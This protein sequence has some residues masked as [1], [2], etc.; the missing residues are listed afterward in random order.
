M[1]LKPAN[2]YKII[3]QNHNFKK[4]L[5]TVSSIIYFFTEQKFWNHHFFMKIKKLK[6][7]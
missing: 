1:I 4:F 7:N 2:K 3:Q 6:R 5:T